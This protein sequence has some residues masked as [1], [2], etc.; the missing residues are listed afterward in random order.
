VSED[1]AAGTQPP[2]SITHAGLAEAARELVAA[3]DGAGLELRAIG[4]V[5]VWE[6]LSGE[7]RAA[8]ESRRSVPRDIDLLAEPKS[9]RAVK[10][11]FEPLEFQPDDRLIAWHGDRRHRYFR[12][13]G[14]GQ[15]LFEVDVF[16]GTPPLCHPIEFSDRLDAAG[17]TMAPTD[18]LLQKLQVHQATEKD[19]VDAAYLLADHPLGGAGEETIDAARIAGLTAS[20]WGF[21]HTATT[22]LG[23]LADGVGELVH[24]GAHQTVAERVHGLAAAIE[25]EPKS[26]RWRMRARVG[27]KVQWYE[28]V[29]ELVR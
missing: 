20:D 28:D 24:E 4:G 10:R 25:Q 11:L 22:N 6:R 8:Y 29:E 27:T 5:A 15:P 7:S 12:L 16:I 1:P 26:R 13:D 18:L 21:H 9:S 17:F 3:A 23:H 2:S 19:L 14:G